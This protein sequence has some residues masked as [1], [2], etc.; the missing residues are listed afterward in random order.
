MTIRIKQKKSGKADM[1]SNT[2]AA[3]QISDT[4]F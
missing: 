3:A 2:S 1:D 4:G